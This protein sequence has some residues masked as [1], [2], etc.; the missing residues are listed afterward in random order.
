MPQLMQDEAGQYFVDTGGGVLQ[1]VNEEQARAFL[2]GQGAG[3]GAF[4]A[5][6][7]GLEN[8]ITGAGSLLSDAPYWQ[9]ANEAGRAQSEAL[10]LANPVTSAGA[11]FAPQA[12]AGLATGGAGLLPTVGVEAALGAATTPETPIQGALIGG[13]GGALP[14]AAGPA[15]RLAGRAAGAAQEAL[16]WLRRADPFEEIPVNP[17][18]MMPGQRPDIPDP[19]AAPVA[20]S[21]SANPPD[22]GPTRAPT[23]L[24][25]DMSAPSAPAPAGAAPRDAVGDLPL[26]GGAVQA[27]R[28]SQRVT[29]AIQAAD[30]TPALGPAGDTRVQSG[31]M[32]PYELY[33]A[34]V[35]TSEGDRLL[36]SAMN[37][38]GEAARA[39]QVLQQEAQLQSNPLLGG[40]INAIRDAQRASATNFLARQLDMPEGVNLTDP[41]MA[42]VFQTVGARMDAIAQAMG[43][44]PITPQLRASMDDVLT[45]A[46]GS[47]RTQLQALLDETVAKA[48]RN[49]GALNGQDWGEMR[50]K[51]GKM[52]DA[53]MRQ[54]NIGKVSDAQELM[55]VL[56]DAMES[57]LPDAA[58]QELAKLRKQYAIASALMKPGAKNAEGQV[59]PLSFYNNWKRPQSKKRVATDDVGR[60]MNTMATLL[61]KRVPDSGTAGRLLQNAAS[62]GLDFIPGGNAAR[63]VLGR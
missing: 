28:M 38:K 17:G 12:L 30:D 11:Q 60:F 42:E 23:D 47:H 59:N 36:L 63:R 2:G 51:L 39:R 62:L 58:Q 14:F 46:T 8:L 21:P 57:G 7:Q 37:G 24:S 43:D 10:N 29:E 6:G 13:A 9:Q 56:T 26:G 20:A 52:V 41:A 35:P 48:E 33:Q 49:L 31:Q 32:S 54:G 22:L 53:G 4:Q 1:P 25:A 27:P 3:E 5:A 55:N 61:M 15:A 16:P 44:I 40:K 34:G 19:D 45:Q 50:T 18:G